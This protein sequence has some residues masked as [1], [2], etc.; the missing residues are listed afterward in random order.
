M[1]TWMYGGYLALDRFNDFLFTTPHSFAPYAALVKRTKRGQDNVRFDGLL[2]DIQLNVYAL[3]ALSLLCI[4]FVAMVN[5]KLQN[6]DNVNTPWEILSSM[7]PQCIRDLHYQNGITR[8]VLILTIGFALL[9]GP[10]YYTTKLLQTL[11]VPNKEVKTS[12]EML[13]NRIASGVS[14]ASFHSE[15]TEIQPYIK[16]SED[17]EMRK[18]A[19]ALKINKPVTHLTDKEMLRQVLNENIISFDG[20]DYLNYALG[21]LPMDEC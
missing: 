16:A 2:A 18:L 3:F 5:E 13:I 11:I 12:F 21:E 14:K 8:K 7:I 19:E 10:T 1:D 6:G 20:M 4:W 17:S 15:N 9:M